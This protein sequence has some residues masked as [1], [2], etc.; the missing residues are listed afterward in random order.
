SGWLRWRRAPPAFI[1][2]ALCVCLVVA[3]FTCASIR[4]HHIGAPVL[5]REVAFA[6]ITGRLI[7][8]ENRDKGWRLTVAPS[9]IEG[10][11]PDKLPARIRVTWRGEMAPLLPGTDVILRGSLSPPPAPVLPGG[12]DFGRYLYFQ[13]IGAVGF[14]VRQPET[15]GQ[16]PARQSWAARIEI[17]RMRL[18]RH[19]RARAPGSG[20]DVIAA[21]VTGKREAI[22]SDAEQALRDSGLAHLLAISGLHMGLATG[23]V[24]FGLRFALACIP[25]LALHWPTKK[26]AAIGALVSG[27]SYLVISGGAVSAR[28]AFIMTFIV[29]IAVLLDRK[30]LSLRNVMIAATVVLVTSPE[31]LLHPGFQMSFA[32]VTAL[33]AVYEGYS[34]R[35]RH[36][37]ATGLT[38]R[39]RAGPPPSTGKQSVL[40]RLGAYVLGI[41]VTDTIAAT[42]TMPFALFHFQ[43]TA[44]YS[45]P[46][47]LVSMPIMGLWIMPAILIAIALMP[48]GLDGMFWRLSAQGI[49]AIIFVGQSV[50]HWPGAV[51]MI[52]AQPGAWLVVTTIGGC[53]LLLL[54]A[55][56]RFAG[57]LAIPL[58]ASLLM[59]TR[60]PAL[61][62]ADDGLNSAIITA[63]PARR[64][65][66]FN[67]QRSRFAVSNWLELVG[68]DPDRQRASPMGDVARCD[69]SGCVGEIRTGIQVAVTRTPLSLADDCAQADLVIAHFPVN[70]RLR[71][72]CA[73]HLIDRRDSWNAGAHAVWVT[74]QGALRVRTAN[75][76]RA[77]RPW[78]AR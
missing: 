37:D 33:V 20:G 11:T 69:A 63:D 42:A 59:V 56:W 18:F 78:A 75:T 32:A 57:L 25:R 19:I 23:L 48:L 77:G 55:P 8:L 53:L 47:N 2:A 40:R 71:G 52:P 44:L 22:S 10:V 62:I 49:T 50:S 39:V 45:L 51:S 13:K 65:G 24:F 60:P 21:I 73:A 9:T 72:N 6:D 38:D 7:Q 61:V 70:R 66:V 28:R 67:R 54:R 14:L 41:G 58:L 76:R 5:T 16:G 26:L 30:A 4:T 74:G 1:R 31:A 36:R 35:R 34:S 27:F 15:G 43:R 17:L 68:L 64:V 46:A 29:L 12:F 3:G